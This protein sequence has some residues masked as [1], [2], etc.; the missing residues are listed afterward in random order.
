MLFKVKEATY[1]FMP[2]G[3][4]S[5]KDVAFN[6]FYYYTQEALNTWGQSTTLALLAA[7]LIVMTG[8]KTG[9]TYL[10]SYFVIPMRSGIVRD[11]RNYVYDKIVTLPIS[12]FTSERKGDVMARMSGDVAEIEN[13]I[14]ASL[15][16]MF[17]NPIMIIV[18]LTTMIVISWQLT[19]F[20]T[21][22]ENMRHRK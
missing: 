14:M 20:E 22:E 13:S 2:L 6:N 17:K 1:E 12:F 11:I 10:A 18:C 7:L 21:L 3:S 5:L 15:D 8:F 16:M 9:A 19:V 4:A